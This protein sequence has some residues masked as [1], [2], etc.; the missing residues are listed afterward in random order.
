MAI[1]SVEIDGITFRVISYNPEANM[2]KNRIVYESSAPGREPELYAA[3]RSRS[4]MGF[5]R[6]GL[7]YESM[8]KGYVDYV[9]ASFIH[10][11]LQKY[12]NTII[13]TIPIPPATN[14]VESLSIPEKIQY[15][16]DNEAMNR[17]PLPG[18]RYSKK[19]KEDNI[20]N[21][22]NDYKTRLIEIEELRPYIRERC[23]S[24][25]VHEESFKE[26]SDFIESSPLF[27]VESVEL[28]YPD[29]TFAFESSSE[30]LEFQADIYC[31]NFTSNA[32]LYFMKYDLTLEL[33]YTPVRPP[34][35]VTGN[36]APLM[37]TPKTATITEFGTYSHYIMGGAYIC[38]IF[39]YN[40]PSQITRKEQKSMFA[41]DKYT[42]VGNRYTN[43]YPYKYMQ[44]KEDRTL[45]FVRP[46]PPPAG[47]FRIKAPPYVRALFSKK[48]AVESGEILPERYHNLSRNQQKLYSEHKQL[49]ETLPPVGQFA[50]NKAIAEGRP[51]PPPG[52]LGPSLSG[53][54]RKNTRRRKNKR[55]RTYKRSH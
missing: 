3:Y 50:R 26:F 54:R 1:P 39:D 43:L 29:Y 12:F 20:R 14:S 9:Q 8:E 30:K 25:K 19:G 16:K 40:H 5:W 36:F 42:Y 45:I 53:G 37:F 47:P 49:L 27:D 46:P 2:G 15:V 48:A 4:E 38:K 22:L 55:R 13:Q 28:I 23:S 21:H 24:T 52:T 41:F 11:D 6:L 51:P 32:K 31:C 18:C 44:L 17:I 34:F 33:N 35:I 10:L 7:G